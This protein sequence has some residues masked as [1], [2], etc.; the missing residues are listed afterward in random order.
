M[1]LLA[2]HDHH[3]RTDEPGTTDDDDLH[4]EP[5]FSVGWKQPS[6]K[7]LAAVRQGR[8]SCT[9]MSRAT[10]SSRRSSGLDSARQPEPFALVLNEPSCYHFR[11]FDPPSSAPSRPINRIE[12][13]LASTLRLPCSAPAQFRSGPRRPRASPPL[14]R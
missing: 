10:L 14:P 5:S 8:D 6:L 4:L 13:R 12:V 11:V 2:E 1:T 9:A 7:S 3:F